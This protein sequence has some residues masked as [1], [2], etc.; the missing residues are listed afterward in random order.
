MGA[1]FYFSFIFFISMEPMCFSLLVKLNNMLRCGCVC[2]VICCCCHFDCYIYD[3]TKLVHSAHTQR[4]Y[5]WK[6]LMFE[7]GQTVCNGTAKSVWKTETFYSI[8]FFFADVVAPFD[9]SYIVFDTTSI[10]VSHFFSLA[11]ICTFHLTFSTTINAFLHK[12]A[13]KSQLPAQWH[14][15]IYIPI[16]CVIWML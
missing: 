15:I 8:Y 11:C 14:V 13:N 5:I 2:I 6:F 7:Y 3:V 1:C 12:N 10:Y 4:K 9:L 16:N